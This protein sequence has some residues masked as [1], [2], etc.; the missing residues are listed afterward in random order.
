M[1]E[2]PISP[3][4]RRMIEDMTVRN[5]VEKT[6]ND[7]IFRDHEPLGGKPIQVTS[8]SGEGDVGDR[9]LPHDGSRRPCHALRGLLARIAQGTDHLPP[10]SAVPG[11]A[12]L[13]ISKR[14]W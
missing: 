3:L 5:F 2:K 6:H 4:R 7:Y 9:E 13:S 10:A 11:W 12:D 1:S 8:V 14:S